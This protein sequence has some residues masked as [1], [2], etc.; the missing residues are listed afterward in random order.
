MSVFALSNLGQSLALRAELKTSSSG[1]GAK[2]K[3][4][5][6]GSGVSAAG[7]TFTKI[8]AFPLDVPHD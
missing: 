2:G 5:R 4:G 7:E 8:E 1:E 3:R 6:S